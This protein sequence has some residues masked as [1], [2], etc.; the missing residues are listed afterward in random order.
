MNHM[1]AETREQ[2]KESLNNSGHHLSTKA[3]AELHTSELEDKLMGLTEEEI[4]YKMASYNGYENL[5]GMI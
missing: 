3:M 4:R 2:I 1:T 5:K